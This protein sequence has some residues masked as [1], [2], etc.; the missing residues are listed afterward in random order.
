MKFRFIVKEQI[1]D[2]SRFLCF[3]FWFNRKYE[4]SI[5]EGKY[6]W[7]DKE[8]YKVSDNATVLFK[9]SKEN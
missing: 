4:Q 7:F 2:G 5:T 1:L 6:K 9:T 8:K 3:G